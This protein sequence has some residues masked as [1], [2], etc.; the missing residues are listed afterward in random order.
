MSALA[1]EIAHDIARQVDGKI[2]VVIVTEPAFIRGEEP[3][4]WTDLAKDHAREIA[5]IYRIPIELVTPEGN[6]VKEVVKLATD[7]DLVIIGSTA[8]NVPFLKPH[9]GQLIAERSPCSVL[10]VTL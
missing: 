9:V 6:T 5:G 1:L 7:H 4:R 3:E 2:S 10:V 8:E